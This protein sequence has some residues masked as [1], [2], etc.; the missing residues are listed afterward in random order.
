[1]YIGSF[2]LARSKRLSLSSF[3]HFLLPFSIFQLLPHP[4]YRNPWGLFPNNYLQRN[5]FQSNCPNKKG[6]SKVWLELARTIVTSAG[7]ASYIAK[8]GTFEEKREFVKKIGSNFRLADAKLLFDYKLPYS[9]LVE[10]QPKNLW[11]PYSI[12]RGNTSLAY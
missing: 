11:G 12:T 8:R 7:Q 6:K 4:K 9:F 1:M 3:W 5:K 10:N 2:F